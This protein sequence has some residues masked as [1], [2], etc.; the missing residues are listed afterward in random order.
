M[1]KNSLGARYAITAFAIIGL[2]VAYLFIIAVNNFIYEN[3][4]SLQFMIFCTLYGVPFL[5]IAGIAN[6]IMVRRL[7]RS[8]W[9][10]RNEITS[11]IIQYSSA[12]LMAIVLTTI[13]FMIFDPN[14]PA[15]IPQLYRTQYFQIS[16][17][18]TPLLN[19]FVLFI[20]KYSEQ[21]SILQSQEQR[22]QQAENEIIKVRYQQL[23]A[24]V[25]PHF[26]FNTLTVLTSLIKTD[27][28]KAVLFTNQLASIYRYILSTDEKDFVPLTDKLRF[29]RK[30]IDILSI[31]YGNGIKIS[32]PT[33]TD[34][35]LFSQFHIIPTS[36]QILIE[37][38]CKH[39]LVTLKRP[40]D[41]N[42]TI[43]CSIPKPHDTPSDEA[44]FAPAECY[45]SVYNNIQP[46][47]RPA[48]STGLGLKG[49][50]QKYRMLTN[51][52]IEINHTRKS[53]EVKIPLIIK[54]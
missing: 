15:S 49:L 46:R 34:N 41:I 31:R 5:F 20:A 7:N 24:Q 1:G 30:Y 32:L 22:L 2:I 26:L 39:N 51:K 35:T 17:I 19:I 23:R 43:H 21:I 54:T 40:L 3:R 53:F 11:S 42:I 18:T 13:A 25:N 50:K 27:Q 48:D 28:D 16:I 45:I 9:A 10:K 4:I 47:P 6:Q 36:I 29:C 8:R 52:N 44:F 14:K 37:N 38:A 33:D 12:I